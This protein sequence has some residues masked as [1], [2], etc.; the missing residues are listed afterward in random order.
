MSIRILVD[1][2]EAAIESKFYFL[3]LASALTVPD[4]AGAISSDDGKATREKYVEWY[5]AWVRP[6]SIKNLTQEMAE[7]GF[8]L[9][10]IPSDQANPLNGQNCYFYRCAMLHQARS[11]HDKSKFSR[12]IFIEPNTTEN[13]LHYEQINDA[14]LIDL[15]SFCREVVQGF[16][17]WID[18]AKET[19]NYK[20]NIAQTIQRYPDGLPDYIGGVP[21]IS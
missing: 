16:G 19:E 15:P 8:T 20:R 4:I 1:Q 9:D 11:T 13:R 17:A 2:L 3:A 18:D 7:R 12:V 6:R 10:K 21:V 14:L 5:E